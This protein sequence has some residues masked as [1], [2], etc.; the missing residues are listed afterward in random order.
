MIDDFGSEFVNVRSEFSRTAS[1]G[2]IAELERFLGPGADLLAIYD[3]VI[4]GLVRVDARQNGVGRGVVLY[5]GPS[6]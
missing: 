6:A 1:L 5:L 3:A 2:E 4:G